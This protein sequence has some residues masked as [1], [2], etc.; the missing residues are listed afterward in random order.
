METVEQ[1]V[2]LLKWRP[3]K[4]QLRGTMAVPSNACWPASGK[5]SGRNPASAERA[6]AAVMERR[7]LVKAG[8]GLG[9]PWL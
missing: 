9:Q 1:P 5:N 2:I 7:Q 4:Q 6:E 3:R 8:R